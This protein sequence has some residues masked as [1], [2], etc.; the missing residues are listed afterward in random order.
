MSSSELRA[1]LQEQK[2]IYSNLM[3][4]RLSYDMTRGK[5]GSDQLDLSKKCFPRNTSATQR[6]PKERSAGI[7]A[8]WTVFQEAKKLMGDILGVLPENIVIGGNSEALI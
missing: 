5:P 2:K 6:Q 7:T 8:Y 3:S 4:E 1:I